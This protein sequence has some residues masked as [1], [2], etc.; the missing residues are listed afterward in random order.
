MKANLFIHDP[1]VTT[2]QISYDLNS[3]PSN[4]MKNIKLIIM[5]MQVHGKVF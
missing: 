5:P 1:K 2:K 4:N 3:E